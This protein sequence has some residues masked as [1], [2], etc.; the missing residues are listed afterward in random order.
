MLRSFSRVNRMAP[1]VAVAGDREVTPSVT[2]GLA[3]AVMTEHF[4]S[5]AGHQI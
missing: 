5:T 1:C 2:T 4:P 3:Q